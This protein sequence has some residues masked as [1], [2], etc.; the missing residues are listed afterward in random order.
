MSLLLVPNLVQEGTIEDRLVCMQILSSDLPL[1]VMEDPLTYLLFDL[2]SKH[3]DVNQV[4]VEDKERGD[5]VTV[6]EV[7]INDTAMDVVW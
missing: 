5:R 3:S 6:A 2:D 4:R 7:P 1:D